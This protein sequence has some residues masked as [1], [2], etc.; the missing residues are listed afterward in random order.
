[1]IPSESGDEPKPFSEKKKRFQRPCIELIK[2][3]YQLRAIEM[4]GTTAGSDRV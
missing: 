1:M 3:I 2:L 4:L